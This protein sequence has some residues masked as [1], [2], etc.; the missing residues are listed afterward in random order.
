[1][2]NIIYENQTYDIFCMGDGATEY[3]CIEKVLEEYWE[4]KENTNKIKY[5][6]EDALNAIERYYGTYAK[7]AW[8]TSEELIPQT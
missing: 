7:D 4:E 2:R 1:M 6:L 8:K 5:P 3:E